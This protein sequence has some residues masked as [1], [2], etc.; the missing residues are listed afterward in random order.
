M[1]M[2]DLGPAVREAIRVLDGVT[3]QDLPGETPCD[4]T[5]VEGLLSH[6]AGL[7]TAF[8]YAAR[9]AQP[10]AAGGQE[11]LDPQWRTSIPRSLDEL[12]QAWRDPSA[13]EGTA[14]AAGTA[15]PA[16]VMGVVALDEVVLHT[17]DL[18]RATGQPFSCEPATTAAVLAFTTGRALPENAAAGDG[19]FGP[20]FPVAD[21]APEFDRALGLAGRD[22]AWTPEG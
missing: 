20:V 3:D 19:V 17:W 6:L 1:A 18:A 8:T 2:L 5:P 22:P 16:A 11:G 10:P 9:K 14:E 12:A 15:M 7:S 13:W 4:G 21:D